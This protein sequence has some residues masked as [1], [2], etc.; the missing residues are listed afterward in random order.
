MSFTVLGVYDSQPIKLM[1]SLN[2]TYILMGNSSN[3]NN[4][5][6]WFLLLKSGDLNSYFQYFLLHRGNSMS[7]T[8]WIFSVSSLICLPGRRSKFPKRW[9]DSHASRDGCL[10]SHPFTLPHL[11]TY[12]KRA[13]VL[14]CNIVC[15]KIY[16]FIWPQQVFCGHKGSSIYF[17]K[18]GDFNCCLQTFSCSMWYLI[19]WP[20]IEPGPLAW[21]HW[22]LATALPGKSI[23]TVQA[24]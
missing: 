13:D 22:V 15:L 16:L 6:W 3:N 2:K 24:L 19:S 21:E 9:I 4:K 17:V 1:S 7:I 11:F 10:A 12:L 8:Y 5:M 23:F 18:C 20:G 14:F